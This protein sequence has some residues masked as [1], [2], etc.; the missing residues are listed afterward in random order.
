ME[1]RKLRRKRTFPTVPF[2]TRIF[3]EKSTRFCKKI[4]IC[5]IIFRRF[6]FTLWFNEIQVFDTV[7]MLPY[8]VEEVKLE[9]GEIYKFLKILAYHALSYNEK[10]HK[11]GSFIGPITDHMLGQ[12]LLTRSS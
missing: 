6:C 2:S 3:V 4:T 10:R 5:L 8:K 7:L 1:F 9:T 12:N 11:S